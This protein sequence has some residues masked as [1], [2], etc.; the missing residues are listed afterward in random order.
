MIIRLRYESMDGPCFER[1]VRT[2]KFSNAL[3]HKKFLVHCFCHLEIVVGGAIHG[4]S[5]TAPFDSL[6]LEIKYSLTH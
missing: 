4:R 5:W 2:F 3:C 1:I 6:L